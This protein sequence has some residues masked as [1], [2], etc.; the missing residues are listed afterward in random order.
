MSDE[1]QV[2]QQLEVAAAL[3]QLHENLLPL[4]VDEHDNV[5]ALH[6]HSVKVG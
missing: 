4:G 6:G 3:L 5:V 1:A 2:G